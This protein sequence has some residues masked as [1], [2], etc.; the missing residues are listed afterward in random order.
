MCSMPAGNSG[1]APG[2]RGREAAREFLLIA[3]G[4]Q[5][6]L[7]DPALTLDAAVEVQR[8]LDPLDVG[9]RPGGDLRIGRDAEPV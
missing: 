4:K 7:L 2:P 3:G 1:V 8:L 6:R 9:G 5:F